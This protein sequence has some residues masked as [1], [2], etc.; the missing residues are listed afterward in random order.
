MSVEDVFGTLAGKVALVTGAGGGIGVASCAALTAAGAKVVATD[1]DATAPDRCAAADFV[2]ADISDPDQVEALVSGVVERFGRI[3]VVH[4]NA[5]IN[6]PGRSHSYTP[7]DYRRVV[8]VCQDANFWLVRSSVGHMRAEGGVFVFTSSMCG[9][10]ALPRSPVYNM[11]KHALIGLAQSVALDYGSQGI[12]AVA[13]VT[14]PTMTPMIDELWGPPDGPM[15]R[16]LMDTTSTGRFAFAE[17]IAR[18]VVF[19]A[20]PANGS[21]TGCALTVDGGATAGW[22]A[23][24]ASMNGMAAAR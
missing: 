13:L 24:R 12:R 19:A 11:T 9:V 1:I 5:G 15:R 10:G 17:E 20:L 8:G 3:D 22:N 14:G 6:V 16:A 23:V 2:R 4:G 18:A 7:D 21:L